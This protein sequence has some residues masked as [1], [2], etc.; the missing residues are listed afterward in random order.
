MGSQHQNKKLET[1]YPIL[2]KYLLNPDIKASDHLQA[3]RLPNFQGS[4]LNF[5]G[6]G[7]I[8]LYSINKRFFKRTLA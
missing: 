5:L 1:W 2:G 3:I 6:S 4:I 8:Q 7:L